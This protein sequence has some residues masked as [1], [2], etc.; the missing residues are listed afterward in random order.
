MAASHADV[1]RLK[2]ERSNIS[3]GAMQGRGEKK[4][5]E[6]EGLFVVVTN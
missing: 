4:K 6:E 2:R 3:T 1:M 5:E